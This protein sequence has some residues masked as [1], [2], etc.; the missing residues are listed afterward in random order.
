MQLEL[1]EDEDVFTIH[2]DVFKNDTCIEGM[3]LLTHDIF[4]H[5]IVIGT[6]YSVCKR[7]EENIKEQSY[8]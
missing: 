1:N 8:N 7:K 4:G 6:T 5:I 2:E 3:L